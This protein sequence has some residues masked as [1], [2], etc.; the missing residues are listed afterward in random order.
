M[1]KVAMLTIC[2]QSF[3]LALGE[4]RKRSA[5]DPDRVADQPH[6]VLAR[7]GLDLYGRPVALEVDLESE[8]DAM[9]KFAMVEALLLLLAHEKLN[10]EQEVEE[11]EGKLASALDR[12]RKESGS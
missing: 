6:A 5:V 10:R 4:K 8:L 9:G 7:E 12:L 2:G 3:D 11:L 1:R